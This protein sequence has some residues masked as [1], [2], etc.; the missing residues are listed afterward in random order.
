MKTKKSKNVFVSMLS[1]EVRTPLTSIYGYAQLLNK[2]SDNFTDAQKRWTQSLYF[3]T[4]RMTAMIEEMIQLYQIQQNS[5]E[6]VKQKF[7]LIDIVE[8]SMKRFRLLYPEFKISII[9]K[10]KEESLLTGDRLKL[11]QVLSTLLTNAAKFSEKSKEVELTIS[12]DTSSYVIEVLD[13]GRGMNKREYESLMTI[14]SGQEDM[15]LVTKCL[16]LYIA[17][18]IVE[19]HNGHIEIQTKR[20]KGTIVEVVLPKKQ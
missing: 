3:E 5:F 8:S 12:A 13:S 4:A 7:P 20:N 19:A 15:S 10:L 16:S 9:N 6:I 14:L 1:H 2:T 17:K 11:T 18:A